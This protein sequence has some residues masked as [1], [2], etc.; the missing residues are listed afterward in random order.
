[1][2]LRSKTI[3]SLKQSSDH[4]HLCPN[5]FSARAM[6]QPSTAPPQQSTVHQTSHQPQPAT[7]QGS[8]RIT[9]SRNPPRGG[10]RPTPHLTIPPT[11]Q[12]WSHPDGATY[13]SLPRLPTSN[14][15]HPR[16]V[17]SLAQ[18][19][20]ATFQPPPQHPTMNQALPQI[21][22]SWG[23]PTDAVYLPSPAHPTSFLAHPWTAQAF[24][25][26]IHTSY[27]PIGAIPTPRQVLPQGWVRPLLPVYIP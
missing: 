16:M 25:Q 11:G 10:G 20:H 17:L 22:Q 21:M 1:M 5:S 8:G 2:L 24:T 3:I 12:G 7:V 19:S 23:Q 18:A 6:T 15:M 26:P 9:H 27:M 13:V 4:S 14:Q